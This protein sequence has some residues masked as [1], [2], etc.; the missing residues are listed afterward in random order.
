[1]GLLDCTGTT[2]EQICLKTQLMISFVVALLYK[3]VFLLYCNLP[4]CL[5]IIYKVRKKNSKIKSVHC[6][7]KQPQIPSSFTSG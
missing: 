6:C 5:H 4:L 1:M 2:N 7:S 3:I